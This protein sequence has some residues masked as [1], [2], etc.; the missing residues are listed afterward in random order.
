MPLENV[1]RSG[2]KAAIGDIFMKAQLD[3]EPLT[4]IVTDLIDHGLINPPTTVFGTY[5]GKRVE[6]LLTPDGTFVHRG[7]VYS[8]PSVA[9]GRAITAE[10]G[11]SSIGR[12]YFSV[13]GWRFWQIVCRDGKTRSLADLREQLLCG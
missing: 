3:P 1:S 6:A 12:K 7:N 9:A 11:I 4:I 13:N 5:T 8:S 10:V 2:T